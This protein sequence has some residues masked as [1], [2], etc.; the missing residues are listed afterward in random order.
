ME[1]IYLSMRAQ[2]AVSTFFMKSPVTVMIIHSNIFLLATKTNVKK[3]NINGH[4]KIVIRQI[5]HMTWSSRQ[6]WKI[7]TVLFLNNWVFFQ[8]HKY[9]SI[10][11][12]NTI[13]IQ[14]WFTILFVLLSNR[15]LK[16]FNHFFFSKGLLCFFTNNLC[17]LF[18]W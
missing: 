14:N 6:H 3:C 4:K 10:R 7:N 5:L 15:V 18:W 17:E 11:S 12:S 2:V 8:S 13:V 1:T 16:F 9:L